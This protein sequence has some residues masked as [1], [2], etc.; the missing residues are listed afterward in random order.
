MDNPALFAASVIILLMMPG[1]TNALLATSG[2]T[3]GF[4]RSTEASWGATLI[5]IT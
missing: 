1:P 3:V 5:H 4:Q 2:A